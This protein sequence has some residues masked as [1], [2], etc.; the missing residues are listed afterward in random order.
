MQQWRKQAGWHELII[1]NGTVRAPQVGLASNGYRDSD[2][3]LR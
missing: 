1:P 3:S 2:V